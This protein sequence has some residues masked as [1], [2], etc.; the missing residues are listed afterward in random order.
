MVLDCSNC[1]VLGPICQ[2][3]AELNFDVVLTQV[4][5][6]GSY[7]KFDQRH[8]CTGFTPDF[9]SIAERI[10]DVILLCPQSVAL[11]FYLFPP[12]SRGN[13]LSL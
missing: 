6:S 12:L 8:S 7:L 1:N 3:D 9:E 10:Y 4:S 2:T 5:A 13:Q 11:S